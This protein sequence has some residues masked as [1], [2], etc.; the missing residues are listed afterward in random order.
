LSRRWSSA[1]SW[2]GSDLGRAPTFSRIDALAL[3]LYVGVCDILD[4]KTLSNTDLTNDI[5]ELE[6]AI[7]KDG[8]EHWAHG[9]R[10]RWLK[11][12]KEA[13]AAR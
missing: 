9:M 8:P 1:A 10:S 4:M 7:A 5:A 3:A 2:P 13:L 12:Y 6:A 11:E